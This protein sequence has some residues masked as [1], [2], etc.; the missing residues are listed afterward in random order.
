MLFHKDEFDK[1]KFDIHGVDEGKVYVNNEG[2]KSLKYFT[3]LHNKLGKKGAAVIKYICYMYDQ[4]SPMKRHFPEL[5]QR[6]LECSQ[7]SGLIK[8]PE[9]HQASMEF[10]SEMITMAI[11]E[12]LKFQNSR[13]WSM[14]V[15]NEEVFYEYQSKLILKTEADH[16][17]DML[18]ALQI[19]SKIMNDMDVIN[20]RLESYYDKLYQGDGELIEKVQIK[21]ISPEEIASLNV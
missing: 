9:L 2:M 18:Q 17:K 6:K 5:I 7:L 21:N 20:Q 3:A 14:I 4:A 1:M 15:S 11:D 10:S 12:F 13:I 8:Y 16:D 19:K